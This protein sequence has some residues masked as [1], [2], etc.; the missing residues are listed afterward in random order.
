MRRRRPIY[1]RRGVPVDKSVERSNAM[2]PVT[3]A[4]LRPMSGTA[5]PKRSFLA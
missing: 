5:S 1:R 4:S 3:L 2:G